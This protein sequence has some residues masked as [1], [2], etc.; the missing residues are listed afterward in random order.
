MWAA[1]KGSM[2]IM[3]LLI[4]RGADVNAEAKVITHSHTDRQGVAIGQYN[5]SSRTTNGHQ[6]S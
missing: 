6:L 1:E 3:K 2:E 4:E 5:F